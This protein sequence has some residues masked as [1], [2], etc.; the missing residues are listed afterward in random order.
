MRRNIVLLLWRL[1]N[2]FS[3]GIIFE[4]ELL[5]IFVAA[6]FDHLESILADTRAQQRITDNSFQ[7]LQQRFG[8]IVFSG[9]AAIEDKDVETVVDILRAREIRA[10]PRDLH[11]VDFIVSIISASSLQT[12]QQVARKRLAVIYTATTRSWREAQQLQRRDI[13][14]QLGLPPQP[15]MVLQ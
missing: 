12:A 7:E 10:R 6:R 2:L 8:K 14:E 13:E 3:A 9:D 1:H 15:L 5:A 11:E 4:N